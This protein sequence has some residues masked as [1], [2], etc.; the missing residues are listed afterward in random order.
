M[1]DVQAFLQPPSYL[2]SLSG[3]LADELCS[4]ILYNAIYKK[5]LIITCSED[6]AAGICF[7]IKNYVASKM[8]DKIKVRISTEGIE[9]GMAYGFIQCMS[10]EMWQSKQ[11]SDFEGLL[12]VTDKSIRPLYISEKVGCKYLPTNTKKEDF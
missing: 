3:T 9:V 6:E 2:K 1:T 11:R 10:L 7:S 5:V 12:L 8:S 4:K